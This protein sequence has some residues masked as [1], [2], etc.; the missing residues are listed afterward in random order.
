L[1]ASIII[2]T[3]NE[4]RW[5]RDAIRSALRQRR[6]FRGSF[7]VIVADGGST[8]G[9]VEASRSMGVEVVVSPR[10]GKVDQVNFAAGRARGRL[11]CLVDADTLLPE[12]Y[13]YRVC[14]FMDRHPRVLACGA[15]FKYTDGKV[16]RWRLGPHTFTLTVYEPL[17]WFVASWYLV[18]DLFKFTELPGCNMCVRRWAFEAVRGLRPVP[19]GMGVDAAF[20]LELRRLARARGDGRLRFLM[21]PAVL[22]SARHLSLSRSRR[23]LGQVRRYLDS[24]R[25]PQE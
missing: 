13:L 20:S 3:F 14:R 18:R 10:R 9:T 23:R 12:D 15:R 24:Q 25:P 7:E 5:I 16:A 11:L 1:D 4:A 8:D 22:T 6:T 17:S 19:H 2:P 21:T